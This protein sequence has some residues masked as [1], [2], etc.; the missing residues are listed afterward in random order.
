MLTKYNIENGKE[1]RINIEMDFSSILRTH[2][3]GR[4]RYIAKGE[5]PN[6][7][8]KIVLKQ[9]IRLFNIFRQNTLQIFTARLQS[10]AV[11]RVPL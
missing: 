3:D 8:N 2:I 6:H 11:L 10:L 1:A 7:I 4:T 5:Q 9:H